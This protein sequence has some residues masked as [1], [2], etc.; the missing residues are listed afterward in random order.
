MDLQTLTRMIDF[1]EAKAAATLEVGYAVNKTIVEKQ[2]S[3]ISLWLNF[4]FAVAKSFLVQFL[5]GFSLAATFSF[6]SHAC[7]TGI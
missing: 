5:F 4:C 6:P 2:V 7:D 1:K 3:D